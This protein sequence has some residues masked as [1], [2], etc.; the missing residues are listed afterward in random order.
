MNDDLKYGDV[1]KPISSWL[2][3]QTFMVIGHKNGGRVV[4]QS[5]AGPLEG[6]RSTSRLVDLVDI[7]QPD[8]DK[9]T[10]NE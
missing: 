4:L 2:N 10:A 7:F 3:K 8:E 6:I 5:L 9:A 1:V